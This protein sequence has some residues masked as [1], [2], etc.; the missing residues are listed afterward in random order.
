MLSCLTLF[1]ELILNL[2]PRSKVGP[3]S[4]RWRKGLGLGQGS[5]GLRWGVAR[6]YTAL[7]LGGFRY[8]VFKP[9]STVSYLG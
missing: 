1:L 4:D 6:G 7:L 3:L 9:C 2:E 8:L 5:G